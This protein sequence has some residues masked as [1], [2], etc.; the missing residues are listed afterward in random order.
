[1]SESPSAGS[2]STVDI[3]RPAL[4]G[5][6]DVLS[7]ACEFVD[8]LL[9]AE[10][11]LTVRYAFDR[12]Y[13]PGNTLALGTPAGHIF[14]VATVEDVQQ[15]SA[16]AFVDADFDGHQRYGNDGDFLEALGVYYP[17]ALLTSATMLTVIFLQDVTDTGPR[18]SEA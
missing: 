14:A 10:K 16:E 7:F 8:P 13:E 1:M 5:I 9:G 12:E 15:M 2:V 3:E 4:S 18:V 11:R 6:D 17:D